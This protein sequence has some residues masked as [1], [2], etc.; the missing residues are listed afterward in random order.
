MV[1]YTFKHHLWINIEHS[2]MFDANPFSNI[3]LHIFKPIWCDITLHQYHK[4][5]IYIYCLIVSYHIVWLHIYIYTYIHINN[6]HILFDFINIYIGI[7]I[8]YCM[9]IIILYYTTMICYFAIDTHIYIIHYIQW[10]ICIVLSGYSL[11][12]GLSHDIEG[13]HWHA[14]VCLIDSGLYCPILLVPLVMYSY[15]MTYALI[16]WIDTH[17]KSTTYSTKILIVVYH[18]II[19][20][21]LYYWYTFFYTYICI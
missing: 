8:L 18:H 10:N 19:I 1:H 6:T 21:L 15:H 3:I 14:T 2:I 13:T 4:I 5:C 17:L 20:L 7:Y 12:T 16:Y 9:S 11:V